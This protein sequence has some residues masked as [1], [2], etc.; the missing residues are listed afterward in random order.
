M[1][2]N[3]NLINQL[4]RHLAPYLNADDPVV[5]TVLGALASQWDLVE[6]TWEE[7]L[8]VFS[9]LGATGDNLTT[10]GHYLSVDRFPSESDAHLLARIAAVLS[11][12]P[13]QTGFQYNIDLLSENGNVNLYTPTGGYLT[14]YDASLS[15]RWDRQTIT[16]TLM[17]SSPA[18]DP[19]TRQIVDPNKPT[20]TSVQGI[21]P[22][23][24]K[25]Q[26]A[27]QVWQGSTN[28]WP[29][30]EWQTTAL[31]P[32]FTPNITSP[33]WT[34]LDGAVPTYSGTQLSSVSGT[35]AVTGPIY[36]EP[37]TWTWTLDSTGMS[38]A[39]WGWGTTGGYFAGISGTQVVLGKGSPTTWTI[40]ASGTLPG[41]ST[42]TGTIQWT[43]GGSLAFTWIQSSASGTLTATDK[44]FISGQ[45]G[46]GNWLGTG[47]FSPQAV[48]TPFPTSLVVQSDPGIAVQLQSQSATNAPAPGNVL[49]ITS[50]LA[51]GALIITGPAL[52][53]TWSGTWS[54]WGQTT[55]PTGT[56]TAQLGS[57]TLA[58]GGYS[59]DAFSL[60]VG[61][62]TRTPRWNI[63]GTQGTTNIG[64]PQWEQLPYATPYI[65]ND[66]TSTERAGEA[67]TVIP[68]ICPQNQGMVGMGVYITDAFNA[69]G[70]LLWDLYSGTLATTTG[71]TGLAWQLST[72]DQAPYTV[73][74][75][76]V[77]QQ[78]VTTW[79]VSGSPPV[80]QTW[81]L[82]LAP[83][84]WHYGLWTWGPLG[85][86]WTWDGTT[87]S[88]TTPPP[89]QP[90]TYTLAFGQNAQ[91]TNITVADGVLPPAETSQW[92]TTTLT[93]MFSET[94]WQGN[95]TNNIFAGVQGQ[96]GNNWVHT[97][98]IQ[99]SYT[100]QQPTGAFTLNASALNEDVLGGSLNTVNAA[101]I[102]SIISPSLPAGIL[103]FGWQRGTLT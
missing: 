22:A 99:F 24:E 46:W 25:T 63:S 14:G 20:F 35:W 37:L 102:Q 6:T 85:W 45:I 16:G 32:T 64:L 18:W 56:L 49:T 41:T 79:Q 89:W 4:R 36:T 73:N 62:G 31:T 27:L 19:Y 70:Q 42:I 40:L 83:N 47:T 5:T 74:C 77:K 1:P 75:Q 66:N 86:T 78:W 91:Y 11:R 84:Q 58:W 21:P 82:P 92:T 54:W 23:N 17:R 81:D 88:G 44:T 68:L 101:I 55:S 60:S 87:L 38:A 57:T 2:L 69:G 10:I 48:S 50:P 61:S 12:R 28:Y 94:V 7:A 80:T 76:W 98:G 30:S 3:I 39:L 8:Q 65:L 71:T 59:W 52:T 103:P 100:A 13:T 97:L 53:T 95:F 96:M 43:A 15:Y 51:S 26:A 90:G 33:Y 67:A 29:D 93:P 34:I 72:V 9:I